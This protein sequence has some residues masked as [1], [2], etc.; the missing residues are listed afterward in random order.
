MAIKKYNPTTPGLRQKVTVSYADLTASRPEKSLTVGIGKSGGRN[1]GGKMTM[2]QL[3]GGAKRKYR[4]I[5]FKRD[6]DGIPGRIATLEYDPNRSAFIALVVYNDGEKRYIVAPDKIK[7]GDTIMSGQKA[8]P[9][10]GHA[11]FLSAVPLGTDIFSIEMV[12]GRGAALVKC[13]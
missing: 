5:D 3:G 6:K 13:W 7:V 11:M 12:P 2:R 4:V 9:E 1:H 10:I 8:Q